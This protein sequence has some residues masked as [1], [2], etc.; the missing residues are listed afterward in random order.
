[1]CVCVQQ[2]QGSWLTKT[3]AWGGLHSSRRRSEHAAEAVPCVPLKSFPLS[4]LPPRAMMDVESSERTFYA[5]T[6]YGSYAFSIL[7]PACHQAWGAFCL[8]PPF[9]QSNPSPTLS[10]TLGTRAAQAGLG[11]GH[12]CLEE[13]HMSQW[14]SQFLV[15]PQMTGKFTPA[16][17]TTCCMDQQHLRASLNSVLCT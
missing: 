14:L 15:H 17:T 1:M 4:P 5:Q 9:Q 13:K 10:P 11:A 3:S 6:S 8:S 16:E 12:P 2:G 7:A